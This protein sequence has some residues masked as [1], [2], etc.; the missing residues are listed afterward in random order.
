MGKVY[1]M[2]GGSQLKGLTSYLESVLQVPVYHVG[3]LSIA[4][5]RITEGLDSDRLNYLINS[6]GI[7]L[8]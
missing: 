8:S 5:I 7:T 1:I 6:V 4:G 3:L 2:G